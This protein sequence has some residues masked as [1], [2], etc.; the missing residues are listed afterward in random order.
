MRHN[1]N[2]TITL[3]E[4]STSG[5]VIILNIMEGEWASSIKALTN[6]SHPHKFDIQFMALRRNCM[7]LI[8]V[9]NLHLVIVCT[10]TI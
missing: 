5:I 10:E 9:Y 7:L 6:S 1:N 2:C 8:F 4:M 3:W